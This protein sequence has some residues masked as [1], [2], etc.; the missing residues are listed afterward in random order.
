MR[1][2][3]E[4]HRDHINHRHWCLNPEVEA[5][6]GSSSTREEIQDPGLEIQIMRRESLAIIAT[7]KG[8]LRGIA[9]SIRRIFKMER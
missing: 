6:E 8:I 3:E 2:L 7:S 5:K 9:E 4:I 1:R